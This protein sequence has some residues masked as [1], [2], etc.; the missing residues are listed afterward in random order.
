MKARIFE[1][2]MAGLLAILLAATVVAGGSP[3]VVD[4]NGPNSGVG[5]HPFN[6]E[7]TSGAGRAPWGD[8]ASG[9]GHSLR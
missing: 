7:P 6:G 1:Q 5:R 4:P 2:G 9:P 8:P 3:T